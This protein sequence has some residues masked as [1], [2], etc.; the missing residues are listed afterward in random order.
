MFE[1]TKVIRWTIIGFCAFESAFFLLVTYV[2]F[3]FESAFQAQ[4]FPE[5]LRRTL[6]FLFVGLSSAY[7]AFSLL[8]RYRWSKHLSAVLFIGLIGWALFDV[9]SYIPPV[10]KTLPWAAPS[11]FGLIVLLAFWKEQSIWVEE[12]TSAAHV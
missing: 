4:W 3:K 1:I 9:F 2:A 10:W 11:G 8:K 6:L 5:N 12:S 7:T